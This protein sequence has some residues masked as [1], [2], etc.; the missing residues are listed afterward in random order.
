MRGSF[1]IQGYISERIL[2]SKFHGNPAT[3]I[4]IIYSPTNS[5]EDEVINK[6]YYELRRAI[7]TI[8]HRIVLIIIGDFNTRK[9]KD[10]GNFT[11]HE[12][13]NKNEVLLIDIINENN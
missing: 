11:Y 13:P 12:E 3:P 2:I 4:I 1:A 6:F 9:G 8:P 7:E 5:S 10:G